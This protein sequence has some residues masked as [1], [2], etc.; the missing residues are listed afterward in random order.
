M[1]NSSNTDKLFITHDAID[2][3]IKKKNESKL[4]NYLLLQIIR[5]LGRIGATYAYLHQLWA[6]DLAEFSQ[7]RVIRLIRSRTRILQKQGIDVSSY[8]KINEKNIIAQAI[9]LADL[10]ED[11]LNS[12]NPLHGLVIPGCEDLMAVIGHPPPSSKRPRQWFHKVLL[13]LE[14]QTVDYM[15]HCLQ[16]I[17]SKKSIIVSPEVFLSREKQVECQKNYAKNHQF[18][19][20]AEDKSVMVV[21]FL[22]PEDAEKK[23]FAKAYVR[24]KGLDELCTSLD[25]HGFF[26]TLTLPPRFHPNPTKG[27]NSWDGSTPSDGRVQMQKNW[28]NFRRRFHE[29]GGKCLGARVLEPHADGCIHWHLLL[30]VSKIR[31]PEFY[32]KLADAFGAGV[33][34]DIRPIDRS[35]ST[36]SSYLIK[37]LNP[38][39]S[40]NDDGQVKEVQNYV[41]KR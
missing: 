12:K 14:R 38:G 10:W 28:A 16:E 39:L 33:A 40:I 34:T 18:V 15:A 27:Q 41:E 11:H 31:I 21:P 22:S 36:G 35:R 26:V 37:Y 20:I 2:Q 6:L 30:Y 24:L 1:N 3:N 9:R 8:F 5:K 4:G 13:R 32:K 29:G 23:R 17:G 25:L 19:T 7:I